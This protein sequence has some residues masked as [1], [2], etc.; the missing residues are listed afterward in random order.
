MGKLAFKCQC[1][2]GGAS[3]PNLQSKHT[4]PFCDFLA[5]QRTQSHSVGL[6]E[7]A[8]YLPGLG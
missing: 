7:S 6:L 2:S 8:T 1:P 4:K 3:S 5:S